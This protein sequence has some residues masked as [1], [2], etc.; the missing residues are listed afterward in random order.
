MR[1]KKST[2]TLLYLFTP[3]DLTI[4]DMTPTF[5]SLEICVLFFSFLVSFIWVWE[6][7]HHFNWFRSL[8]KKTHYSNSPQKFKK[9][10]LN[11][12]II[13]IIIASKRTIRNDRKIQHTAAGELNWM[14]VQNYFY[15]W[16]SFKVW[17]DEIKIIDYD[18][19]WTVGSGGWM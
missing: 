15:F 16:V 14:I 13:I 19:S 2:T 9:N 18:L 7:H 1:K 6:F 17:C 11:G 5:P 8:L 12:S 4:V 3:K 10:L